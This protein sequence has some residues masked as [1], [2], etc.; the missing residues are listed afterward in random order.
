M[1][2]VPLNSRCFDIAK[3]GLMV[4]LVLYKLLL[5]NFFLS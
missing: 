5:V 4:Q 2:F 3:L 1:F